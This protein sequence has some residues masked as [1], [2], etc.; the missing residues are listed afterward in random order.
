MFTLMVGLHDKVTEQ[1]DLL[2]YSK[3]PEKPQR[4]PRKAISMF[5]PVC[6]QTP[7]LTH[8]LAHIS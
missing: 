8:I 6:V 1:P 4:W 3:H 7:V 2:R 5:I